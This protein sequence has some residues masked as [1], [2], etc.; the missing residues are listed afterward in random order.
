[1]ELAPK[2]QAALIDADLTT[3]H[4]LKDAIAAAKELQ[5][6]MNAEIHPALVQLTAVQEQKKRFDKWK[7][8]FSHNLSRYLNNLFIHIVSFV[9]IY[10]KTIFV[11]ILSVFNIAYICLFLKGND[12][13]KLKLNS[14]EL[15]LPVRSQFHSDLG[16]YTPLMHW[17]KVMDRKAYVALIKIYTFSL[18]KLYERDIKQFMEEAKHRVAG[19][20]IIFF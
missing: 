12:T 3:P 5:A 17:C 20:T 4:G 7:S 18:G 14:V 16:A 1:M 6:V 8:K 11:T 19:G 15:I 10:L 13:S 2:H 9:R